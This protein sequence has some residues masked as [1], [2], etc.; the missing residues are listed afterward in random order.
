MK[1][2]LKAEGGL[3]GAAVSACYVLVLAACGAAAYALLTLSLAAY[4]DRGVGSLLT[5]SQF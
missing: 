1:S 3:L 5:A 4:G 2:W